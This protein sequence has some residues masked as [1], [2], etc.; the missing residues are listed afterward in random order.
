MQVSEVHCI[1]QSHELP[2]WGDLWWDAFRHSAL[3]QNLWDSKNE[4]DRAKPGDG[5]PKREEYIV[6]KYKNRLFYESPI[7]IGKQCLVV[8]SI[9]AFTLGLFFVFPF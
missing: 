2:Q 5:I 7:L 8:L 9:S 1:A 4:D 6:R 3:S